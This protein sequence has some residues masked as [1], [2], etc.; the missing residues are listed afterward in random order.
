MTLY[1]NGA[2]V[3]DAWLNTAIGDRNGKLTGSDGAYFFLFDPAAALS[4]TYSLQVEKTG[5]TMSKSAPAASGTYVPRLGGAL[6]EIV[7]AAVPAASVAQT[8]YLSFDFIF[9]ADPATTSNGVTNN[10]IPMDFKLAEDVKQDV[11][12]ILTRDLAAT[13]AQQGQRMQGYS[14]GAL[15][16][17]KSRDGNA[18]GAAIDATLARHPVKFAPA[19][20]VITDESATVLAEL[21]R[22]LEA[23]DGM[24]FE[25][26]SHTDDVGDTQ[27]NLALSQQRADAVVA[28]LVAGGIDGAR[29]VSKGYGESR[30]VADTT[31][32]AG[33]AAN[34][35]IAFSLLTQ[36][37]DPCMDSS[38]SDHALSA[39]VQGGKGSVNGSFQ[40]E[41]H[42][43]E[44][45]R[46]RIVSG[47]ASL[48]QTERG[49]DQAM[50]TFSLRGERF[51]TDNR[52][53]GRFVGAY[54][55]RSQVTGT[56][57]G[58]ILGY[59]L[60]AGIYGA[61]RLSPG[62][63]LDYY[64]GAAAG[65][66]GFDLDFDR[67]VGVIKATGHYTYGALFAGAAVSGETR[68]MGLAASPRGGIDLAWSP[69]GKGSLDAAR[70]ALR[71]SSSLTI[72]AV[73]GGRAY[74]DLRFDDL[75]TQ[76]PLTL[77]VTPRLLCDWGMGDLAM[78]CGYG[79][80]IEF[81][82]EAS[83][84]GASFGLSLEASRTNAATS[85]TVE[86]HYEWPLAVGIVKSGL[87]AGANGDAS[88]GGNYSLDF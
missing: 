31:T 1:Y 36:T 82:S 17:L 74:L 16:R 37:S 80:I 88:I 12:D 79:G 72:P 44:E 62:L 51:V 6:E 42:D 5:Y 60:N 52:V 32:D 2:P 10:H 85:A 43:C 83:D 70:G 25:V 73:M 86:L 65:R 69:G 8:Y 9:T 15:S 48:L 41:D 46:W 20:A 78:G 13:M 26:S 39:D 66:H 18:C 45:D 53:R 76:S 4:G 35:R 50:L 7:T 56:G 58:T 21:A 63:Y 38:T 3:P 11:V 27:V 71:D 61:D 75:L 22:I 24:R 54:A 49:L 19:S 23:C 34:Q 40:R 64:L 57:E 67:A 59:G 55:S 68:I 47:E 87:Q 30:P 81:S 77:A 84:Q 14:Q 28:A 29:L 33:R